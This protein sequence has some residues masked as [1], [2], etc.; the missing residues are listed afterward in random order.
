MQLNL[1]PSSACAEQRRPPLDPFVPILSSLVTESIMRAASWSLVP[2]A[3]GAFVPSPL[4]WAPYSLPPSRP[5]PCPPFFPIFPLLP[6]TMP[7]GSKQKLGGIAKSLTKSRSGGAGGASRKNTPAPRSRKGGS[8]AVTAAN[9][10]LTTKIHNR[11]ET[12]MAGRLARNSG[13]LSTLARSVG[14]GVAAPGAPRAS[15]AASGA[16]AGSGD[17]AGGGK[18]KKGPPPKGEKLKFNAKKLKGMK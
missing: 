1:R 17:K 16:A 9:R 7:Q 3:F 8:N 6:Y 15:S 5:P 11:I 13:T 4:P 12:E 18:S 14:G 2:L 10:R